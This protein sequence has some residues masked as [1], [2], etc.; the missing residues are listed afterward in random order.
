MRGNERSHHR[1]ATIVLNDV[2]SYAAGSQ[3]I[4]LAQERTV[5]TNDDVRDA[6]E[7]D[8]AGAHRARR[9][10]R[11]HDAVAIDRRRLTPGAFEGIH[12]AV[13]NRTA[14]LHAPVVPAPENA[15]AVRERRADRN[16]AFAKTLL[17]F[18]D[19]GAQERGIMHAQP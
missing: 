14:L 2:H 17:G 3:Q 1:D 9:E 11:V 19:R 13:K 5:L 18:G 12:L 15:L 6:I 8:R 7:K 16:A 4:L 10:R